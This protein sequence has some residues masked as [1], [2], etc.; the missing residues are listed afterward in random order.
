M[1]FFSS[2][3]DV[4]EKKESLLK[5]KLRVVNAAKDKKPK[6][7]VDHV[8]V[9]KKDLASDESSDELSKKKGWFD[10]SLTYFL[11]KVGRYL[12]YLLSLMLLRRYARFTLEMCRS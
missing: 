7:T 11:K 3:D 10:E 12:D 1:F 8:L 4:T 9:E 2:S 6:L 5:T